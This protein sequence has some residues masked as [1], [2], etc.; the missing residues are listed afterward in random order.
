MPAFISKY[1]KGVGYYYTYSTFDD[2]ESFSTKELNHI[3]KDD[4]HYSNRWRKALKQYWG[5]PVFQDQGEKDE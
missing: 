4:N 1:R 5:Q 3:L 2:E